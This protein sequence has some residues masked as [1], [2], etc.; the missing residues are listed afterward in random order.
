[1]IERVLLIEPSFFVKS[2][3]ETI[4]RKR[5][6][7]VYVAS[8]GKEAIALL[9]KS[10]PEAIISEVALPDTEIISFLRSLRHARPNIKQIL[11]ANSLDK[12]MLTDIIQLGIKDIFIKPFCIEQL[13]MKFA[14]IA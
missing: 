11:I 14:T 1:M 6:I 2:Q 7:N 10:F 13:F 5:G 9:S 12:N 3:L 4:L 8:S